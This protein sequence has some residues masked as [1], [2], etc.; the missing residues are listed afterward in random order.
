M[1]EPPSKPV[2]TYPCEWEFRVIGTGDTHLRAL[3]ATVAG[4]REHSV[5]TGNA[6]AKYL[7][8]HLSLTVRDETD[9]NDVYQRLADD[10][11]VKLVL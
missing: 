11:Q 9:R 1:A 2:I 6:N 5:S 4:G 7:A 3:I 8:L 10:T